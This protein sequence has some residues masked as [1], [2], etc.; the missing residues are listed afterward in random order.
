MPFSPALQARLG[1]WKN[2][3]IDTTKRNR[4]LFFRESKSGSIGLAKP[5]PE[6][7]FEWLVG[8]ERP[9]T[10]A[11]RE[12][13]GPDEALLHLD[14][15]EESER[16]A[17]LPPEPRL[18]P[19]EVLADREDE[20]LN[21]V[22]YNLRLRGRT[23]VAEQG[24][25]I[26]F[27]AFGLL[28][29]IDPIRNEE[30]AS[31]L[32]LAPV[33]LRRESALAPY[34]V[35]PVEEEVVLNPT[36]AFLLERDCHLI[37]PPLPD[38]L[39]DAGFGEY[40]RGLETV[41]A[42]QQGWSIRREAHLGT[43]SFQKLVIYKDLETNTDRLYAHP[44]VQALAGDAR[45]LE[46]APESP[47]AEQLDEILTPERTF[48]ILDA[49]SSQQE[50][51]EA[52]K[53][54]V[55]LVLQGPPGTGKSQTIANLIAEML[56][57]GKRV[58]F[59]SEKMAAL[60]VVHT[61]L[62]AR[63]LDDFCLEIHSA[64][65][66]KGEILKELGRVLRLNGQ[67][68]PPDAPRSL[69]RLH[70]LRD[71][72]NHYV[73]AL[74]TPRG[75]AAWTPFQIHG[76]LAAL[77]DAPDLHFAF[78]DPGAVSPGRLA[79][80]DGLLLRVDGV[81][82]VIL[83]CETHP[84]RGCLIPKFT[85]EV[86]ADLCKRFT[87]LRDQLLALARE[88]AT[89]AGTCHV[90][91][92]TSLKEVDWLL[93]LA[94]LIRTTPRPPAL[95][96]GD[97]DLK[98]LMREAEGYEDR[99]HAYLERRS[100]L[101]SRY[102]GSFLSLLLGRLYQVL[103][104][105]NE[106]GFQVF[107]RADTEPREAL[108][109]HRA[110]LAPLLDETT[111]TFQ[112]LPPALQALSSHAGV[113]APAT[114]RG[115][116]RLFPL[117]DLATA[118]PRPT[119]E[120]FDRARLRAIRE[121]ARRAGEV[122]PLLR[123]Q[124]ERLL[125]NYD[126]GILA[127]DLDAIIHRFGADYAN[128]TRLVRPGY[129]EDMRA[130][131]GLRR[132]PG[133]LTV[134]A[135]LADLRLAREVRDHQ[136]WVRDNERPLDEEL[137]AWF[138]GE[139][140]SWAAAVAALDRV[141]AILDWFGQ[142]LPPGRFIQLLVSSGTE[143]ATLQRLYGVAAALIA[144]THSGLGKLLQVMEPERL[145][146]GNTPFSDVEFVL[147][148][149]WLAPLQ[150]ACL[151]FWTAQE[152][153]VQEASQPD[154]LPWKQAIED[155]REGGW[156]QDEAQALASVTD[157]LRKRYGHFFNGAATDWQQ[158]VRALAWTGMFQD[159][160]RP[161]GVPEAVVRL[162]CRDGEDLTPVLHAV[163]PCHKV[164][165][166]V[167]RGVD[168][169][170]SLF[171]P[172]IFKTGG[173]IEAWKVEAL[174][175][176]LE[177]RVQRSAALE[178]WIDFRRIQGECEEAGLESFFA[179]L[180]L[181]G[182]AEGSLR[183]VFYRRFYRLWLDQAYGEDRL[184]GEFR[185]RDHERLIDQFRE[186]DRSQW[187]RLGPVRVREVVLGRRP[188]I[189][190]S[191]P[192]N[193]E[194]WILSRELE[195]RRR[196][197]P[198]RQLFGEIPNL[199]Q[200][201]KP[202]LLMS[203]MTVSQLLDPRK[204]P[205]DLVIFDEASQICAEDAVGAISRGKQ[206]VVA[207]DRHQLPPTRFFTAGL[208]DAY[209]AEEE[210]EA[211]EE[212]IYESILDQCRTMLP[213]KALKWHYRSRHESLIAFSNVHI[214]SKEPQETLKTFPSARAR[215]PGLGIEL[216]HVPE[217]VYDRKKSRRNP[218]EARK[219]AELVI[220]HMRCTPKR[221]LGVV[222]FSEA[223]QMAILAE[224]ERLRW[225]CRELDG[226]FD[227][228]REEPFFVK[229]LENVQGDERD[230]IFLNVGYGRDAEGNLSLNFGPL[231]RQGGERRLNV[232]ITRA[233]F[234]LKLV[235]SLGASDIDLART[236]SRGMHL[237]RAYLE[238]SER[239]PDA[240]AQPTTGDHSEGDLSL[241][242]AVR[243]ALED[244]GHPVTAQ[245]GHGGYRIDLAV[246]DPHD[247]N[248]YVLGVECEGGEYASAK[249]ARDRDRLSTEVL[250]GYKDHPGLGWR[251]HRV[252]SIDWTKDPEG[253]LERIEAALK[254]RPQ[255]MEV[256]AD[257]SRHVELDLPLESAPDAQEE[258]EDASAPQVEEP[259]DGTGPA[260]SGVIPYRRAVLQTRGLPEDF[261]DYGADRR[262]IIDALAEVVALEGP[263][264]LIEA[265]R[266]VAA[267]WDLRS[268]GRQIQGIVAAAAVDGTQ[269]GLFQHREGFLWPVELE[270]PPV[271]TH[272]GGEHTRKI[273]EICLEEVAE[274]A[275]LVMRRSYSLPT[276]DL[277][278]QTA[279]T[280]GFSRTGPEVR[281]RI[282]EAVAHL[283]NAGRLMGQDGTVSLCRQ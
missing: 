139:E 99:F 244:R 108:W 65:A 19:G 61:R 85:F 245:V 145:P 179:A 20:P 203:P 190:W 42:E 260:P 262:E 202:C 217:A 176:W 269:R 209:D 66:S 114:M 131:R 31:P 161:A 279:R 237:L 110:A 43:F 283:V 95:W 15:E 124:R 75:A 200:E 282:S 140:T 92:P 111:R 196:H 64:K 146:F 46:A 181:D 171:T 135:A 82:E 7:L 242:D 212:E 122:Y 84:W 182:P 118:D 81:R 88:G 76:Q 183:E 134:A 133:K 14:L 68:A 207:G 59:V 167:Q 39:D 16:S 163:A 247:P 71:H 256:L 103:A 208:S 238:Y 74:H 252:W 222:A 189:G 102:R 198:L 98:Q 127:L 2:Q 143:V 267:A 129:W 239:G 191:H 33:E 194:P 113:P 27:V 11:R 104:A 21:R 226:L 170:T 224:V 142:A 240:L 186:L 67:P 48:Q 97:L 266:R 195:K 215:G 8:R 107:R 79:G 117:M 155:L 132:I 169:L 223:Q 216:V 232:A 192:P 188:E 257:S 251:L 184:L 264:R 94:E 52:V 57:A 150:A 45:A 197:K 80:L 62:K 12:V 205:F 13:S 123:T 30:R 278:A 187:E 236:Q 248:R 219:V 63:R 253:E 268:A 56:A 72:L 130:L 157:R 86:Q 166:E 105:E 137:G 273:E 50:A 261:Y 250:A 116:Q 275:M 148:R 246:R 274:A 177:E 136:H 229:N 125:S 277:V 159:L 93:Q 41:M 263:I 220:Q 128:L 281:E 36:L 109:Q 214:Y 77:Q 218:V 175:V 154:R 233:K 164:R 149:E 201:L 115:V 213:V 32:I 141:D 60:Q 3:L 9:L 120:W 158:L 26:L 73:R 228:K 206:V 276:E 4:L 126:P 70:D 112:E 173:G 231:N 234:H 211:A 221:S 96:F 151:G 23:A 91:A 160:F 121:R 37:L 172:M 178:R 225:H 49:D 255:P 280:L 254:Q 38:D 174:C 100:G 271:R 147:L 90:P 199:I 83:G 153:V 47:S 78:A 34:R 162:V 22:L 235:T 180:M 24:V 29:W 193:S 51:I 210:A 25:N 40:C 265:T 156:V 185:G 227:E 35:F 53:R 119:A 55:S 270:T 69:S 18:S 204:F 1:Q 106:E 44:I 58:L 241:E 28:Q 243:A 258:P 168:H 10:F 5:D 272:E 89:L 165:L 6:T 152:T 249:T 230:V 138:K 17:A 259:R 54:G 144:N 101:F 87:S